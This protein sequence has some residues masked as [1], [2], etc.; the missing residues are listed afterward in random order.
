MILALSGPASRDLAEEFKDG[1]VGKEYIARVRG[2]FPAEE[3]LVDQPLL[4]VDRQMGLVIVAPQGKVS[5][6]GRVE[7]SCSS[8]SLTLAGIPDRVQAHELRRGPRPEC[9]ALP[10]A[11][12]PE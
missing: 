9:R 8:R 3:V 2:C 12:W 5:R 7:F 10:P 1:K 4:T 11:H 6:V